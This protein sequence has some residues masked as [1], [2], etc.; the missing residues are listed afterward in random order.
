MLWQP[1]T[2]EL[3]R[4]DTRRARSSLLLSDTPRTDF[5][6][7]KD[8]FDSFLLKNPQGKILDGNIKIS[9]N[10]EFASDTGIYEVRPSST[11]SSVCE[12]LSL[13]PQRPSLLVH[14]GSNRGCC[15][16]QIY[17]QLCEGERRLED[18]AREFPSSTAKLFKLR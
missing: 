12:V 18:P 1:A 8:Y 17:V 2:R 3:L 10:G 9:E 16:G 7:I 13:L 11:C 4:A 5:D 6:T 15:Q 14:H